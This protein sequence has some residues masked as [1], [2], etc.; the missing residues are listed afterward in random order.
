[1]ALLLP[2]LL[3]LA[4]P[5]ALVLCCCRGAAQRVLTAVDLVVRECLQKNESIDG[6]ARVVVALAHPPPAGP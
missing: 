5:D 2:L 4:W 3:F 6:T 1:M